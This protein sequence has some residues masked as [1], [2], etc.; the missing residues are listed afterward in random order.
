MAR[1]VVAATT[2][3]LARGLQQPHALRTLSRLRS[4]AKDALEQHTERV[5]TGAGPGAPSPERAAHNKRQQEVFD[6]L[7]RHESPQQVSLALQKPEGASS[8]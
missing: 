7:L 1:L 6:S 4:A 8:Q 3:T 5:Q 2:L